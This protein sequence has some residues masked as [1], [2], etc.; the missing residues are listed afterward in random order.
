MCLSEGIKKFRDEIYRHPWEFAKED[1]PSASR[2]KNV[3]IALTLR[4]SSIP[5]F[6]RE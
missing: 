6:L 2:D 4:I 3:E 1:I 5:C